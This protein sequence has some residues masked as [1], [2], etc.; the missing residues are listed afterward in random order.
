LEVRRDLALREGGGSTFSY[1]ENSNKP[2][3]KKGIYDLSWIRNGGS[4]SF[5]QGRVPSNLQF[6][7]LC[8][9]SIS[10]FSS[11]LIKLRDLDLTKR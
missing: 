3:L 1:H 6:F 4:T 5:P 8:E 9:L 7:F 2:I 11:A 10:V